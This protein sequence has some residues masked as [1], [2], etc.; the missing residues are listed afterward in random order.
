MRHPNAPRPVRSRPDIERV[1]AIA[2]C[3]RLWAVEVVAWLAGLIGVRFRPDIREEVHAAKLCVFLNAVARCRQRGRAIRAG[4]ARAAP[5]GIRFQHQRAALRTY[6]RV[7]KVR[8]IK[9]LRAL[10]D[11]ME[12]AIAAM[13]KRLARY[14]VVV[15]PVAFAPPAHALMQIAPQ[16]EPALADTS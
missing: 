6:T 14:S 16:P 7:V 13:V 9:Q 3:L 15:R 10:L 12:P 2:Q 8:G 4:R 11:D 1:N 5:P